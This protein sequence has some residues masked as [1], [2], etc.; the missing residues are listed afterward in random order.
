MFFF[1]A[2]I[3]Q[4]RKITAETD[5]IYERRL[6]DINPG[7]STRRDYAK[8]LAESDSGRIK[9]PVRNKKVRKIIA[10]A[11]ERQFVMNQQFPFNALIG[12]HT[13]CFLPDDQEPSLDDVVS[14]LIDHSKY[15]QHGEWCKVLGPEFHFAS[16]CGLY[17]VD[18]SGYVNINRPEFKVK[19]YAKHGNARACDTLDY[20]L[21]F[22]WNEFQGF[23][24]YDVKKPVTF[25]RLHERGVALAKSDSISIS[26]SQKA[27]V[28]DFGGKKKR[29]D[30]DALG[31]QSV[32]ANHVLWRQHPCLIGGYFAE[33]LV[34]AL[35]QHPDV[36]QLQWALI[37][38]SVKRR[39]QDEYRATCLQNGYS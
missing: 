39:F 3:T 29:K 7:K 17:K 13:H 22:S 9:V 10:L 14:A 1:S 15:K 30:L 2:V 12:P 25:Y 18:V 31:K 19:V 5:T 33:S 16:D 35:T 26:L 24:H 32:A 38:S 28:L 4:V 21:R 20:E 34:A 6:N 23:A 36:A 8:W 11:T 27:I 37:K